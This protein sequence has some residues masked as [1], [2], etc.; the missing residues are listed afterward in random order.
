MRT[1]VTLDKDVERLL[2]DEMHRSRRSFKQTLN[3]AIR[4]A[5][6]AAPARAEKPFIIKARDLGLRAGID[7][8]GFNQLAD[9][10]EVEAF[11]K[12]MRRGKAA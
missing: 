8:A 12:K 9:E 2:K 6:G 3:A 7:P 11:V 10:L 4:A 1:T 5:L